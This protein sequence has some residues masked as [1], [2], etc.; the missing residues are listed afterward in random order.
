MNL[1]L[2]IIHCAHFVTQA[3]GMCLYSK[4][5]CMHNSTHLNSWILNFE[6]S[7]AKEIDLIQ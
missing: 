4:V 5:P 2:P 7:V 3:L 6:T 1:Y